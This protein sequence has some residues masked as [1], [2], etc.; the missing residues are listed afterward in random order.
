MW[1]G[2]LDRQIKRFIETEKPDIVCLQEAISVAHDE[3]IFFVS[4]ENI[5]KIG[6]LEYM[7]MAPTFSM[8]YMQQTANYGNAILSRAPIQKSEVIFTHL[9][10]VFDLNPDQDGFNINMRNFVHAVIKLEGKSHHIITHHGFWV[11]EH[12]DGNDE[13]MR[14]MRQLAEYIAILEGPVILTGDFNL[15]PHSKSL[16]QLNN[17]L[18]NL[19]I[20]YK[21]KTTR[22]SLTHKTEVCDYI[23]VS[24]DVVVNDFYTS[25]EIVSDHQA[26]LLEFTP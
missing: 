10:H 21:L 6:D 16:E 18:T 12:K 22:N 7:V 17:I 14:Q 11:P 24:K 8:N 23:F 3:A 20:K 9:E 5:Q 25:D 26:L 19:S 1:G 4:T 2:R 13:T 15:A